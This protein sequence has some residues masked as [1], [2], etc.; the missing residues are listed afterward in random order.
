MELTI[1]Q[2]LHQGITAHKEG[3]L[4]DA[5]RVYRAILRSQPLHPDANHNLG[6]LAVS[7]NKVD[8]ALPLFKTALKAN[9][10]KEQFWFSYI[11]ALIKEQKLEA[12]KQVIEQVKSKGM[13]A[14]KLTFFESQLIATNQ[15]GESQSVQQKK[16]PTFATKR[17]K[18]AEAKKTKEKR[19]NPMRVTVHQM[20]K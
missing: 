16:N 1:E 17:K 18:I 7:G 6:V 14:G 3:R 5:E 8:A 10:K 15:A 9:P 12:A 4:Q 2:A 13:A 11:D 20:Q 19:Q